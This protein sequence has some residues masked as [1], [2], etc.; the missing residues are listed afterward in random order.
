MSAKPVMKAGLIIGLVVWLLAPIGVYIHLV[1]KAQDLALTP[2]SATWAPIQKNRGPI[3]SPVGL[4][5]TWSDATSVFAPNWSGG[6]VQKV[7][8]NPGQLLSSGSPLVQVSGIQIRAFVTDV[9][10]SKPVGLGD[11]GPDASAAEQI[12]GAAGYSVPQGRAITA[13]TVKAIGLFAQSIGV[14]DGARQKTFDPGWVVFLSKNVTISSVDVELGA[15]A[16]PA[17]TPL[18]KGAPMLVGAQTITRSLVDTIN[19]TRDFDVPG[20][21]PSDSALT[22]PASDEMKIGTTKLQLQN[23][24]QTVDPSSFDAL[25]ALVDGGAKAISAVDSRPAGQDE[26]LVPSPAIFVSSSGA[27]CVAERRDGQHT[28]AVNTKITVVADQNGISVVRGHFD[29]RE[30]VR[31]PAPKSS[32]TCG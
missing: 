1:G 25:M 9:P 10:L 20:D 22:I 8:V 27:Y 28:G 23:D 17:G 32:N 15:P 26:W 18:L 2:T 24:R 30:S 6:V 11:V 3:S 19:Q 14:A 5:L 13:S 12:L 16:P 21:L 4:A 29:G 7:Y 31:L